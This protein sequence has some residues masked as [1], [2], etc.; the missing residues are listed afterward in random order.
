VVGSRNLSPRRGFA[1]V[2]RGPLFATAA[3]ATKKNM[4]KDPQAIT[5]QPG[6]SPTA[7]ITA[8]HDGV[9]TALPARLADEVA[10][11]S[12]EGY[13]TAPDQT[14]TGWPAGI[15]YIVGNE[16][17]ERFSFYGMNAILWA[18]L[19]ALLLLVY[20]VQQVADDLATYSTHLFKAG[21]YTLPVLGAILSDRLLG[22]FRTIFYVSLIYCAG[23]GVL[24]LVDLVS[25]AEQKLNVMYLGLALIAIGSG[26]IKP[27]VGANVGDQFGKGNWFRVRTIF[28]IF[29]FSVNFGSFLATFSIPLVRRYFGAS[30]AFAIPGV[31]MLLATV[32]FW[33][34]RRKFVHV[35]P[36]PGGQVGLLDTLSSFLLL[37]AVGHLFFTKDSPWYVMVLATVVCLVL[38]LL[39]FAWR[40]RLQPDAG[41][42]AIMSYTL[43][44]LFRDG[45]DAEAEEQTP[46]HGPETPRWANS[47]FWAPAVRR[48]GVAATE[49]PVAVLKVISVFFLISM[50]WALF[51]QHSTSWIRQ[52]RMMDLRWWGERTVEATQVPSLNPL[53]VMV[54]IPLMNLVYLLCDRAGIQTSPLRRITVGMFVASLA[55]VVLALIQG[56]IDL[57][58]EGKVWFVWQVVPYLLITTAEVL[59]GVTALEFAYTQAPREMKSTIVAFMYF[60]VAVGNALVAVL[61]KLGKLPLASFFL[62][63]AVL[64][65]C[66]AVLFGVRAVFY[67]QKDYPQ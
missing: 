18:Q 26:G 4:T 9:T 31:L 64:M 44:R 32:V 45:P 15:P 66:A 34:G 19:S 21:V 16:A 55:F 39:L 53:M 20:Q 29:Y 48:F 13:R 62:V 61:A 35:P 60:T 25:E 8:R 63:F 7:A 28:Q 12:P 59:V 67:T 24:A 3:T 58:G 51:D 30:V 57:R 22:K 33:L 50:F 14:T 47:W 52:A 40:Q 37:M 54:L 23:H 42:L 65:A 5:A 27:C 17:C 56:A 6:A 41:F 10:P 1:Q 43:G 36:R 2:S 49:G 46:P 11:L 38:G